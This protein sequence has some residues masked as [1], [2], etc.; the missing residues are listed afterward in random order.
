MVLKKESE[1]IFSVP[2]EIGKVGN[3]ICCRISCGNEAAPSIFVYRTNGL[4]L[5]GITCYSCPSA[6]IYAT[7]GNENFKFSNLNVG[8]REGSKALLASN[9]DCIHTK[10]LKGELTVT[11]S[12]FCGIGD[13]ALNSHTKLCVVDNVDGNNVT[14]VVGGSSS[15]PDDE[16]FNDGDVVE[17]IGKNYQSIGTAVVKEHN[18]KKLSCHHKMICIAFSSVSFQLCIRLYL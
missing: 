1:S 6:F 9:E 2:M 15:A 4:Y 14:C 7:Y 11:D 5:D 16:M 10:H 8:V 12:N 17:F 3:R 18:G 13:D